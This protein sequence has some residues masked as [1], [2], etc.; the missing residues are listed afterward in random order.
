MGD[1]RGKERKGD[2][3]EWEGRV[4]E[5]VR[6]WGNGAFFSSKKR[7]TSKLDV[8]KP[9]LSLSVTLRT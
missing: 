6:E 7:Y 9:T 5:D 2:G 4:G 1:R 3:R 8:D